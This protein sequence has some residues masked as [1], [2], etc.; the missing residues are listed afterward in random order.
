M[1]LKH[2]L[3]LP[4]PYGKIVEDYLKVLEVD[5]EYKAYT[6]NDNLEVVECIGIIK[7][8]GMYDYHKND[9]ISQNEMYVIGDGIM[10]FGKWFTLNKNE[11]VK[12]QKENIK[13]WKDVLNNELNRIE[14]L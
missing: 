7:N 4:L 5:T 8:N 12:I 3:N 1:E 10:N 9:D 11:A 13:M 14:N 6:V 2:Y